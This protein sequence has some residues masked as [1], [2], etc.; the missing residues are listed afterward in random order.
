MQNCNFAFSAENLIE[1]L[2]QL[3]LNKDKIEYTKT[4][5]ND[6]PSLINLVDEIR[7]LVSSNVRKTLTAFVKTVGEY[8]SQSK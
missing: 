1:F 7:P 6:L 2:A 3:R 4:L 8:S 5:T